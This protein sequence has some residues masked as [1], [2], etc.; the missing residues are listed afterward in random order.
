M[1]G[2]AAAG[3][4]DQVLAFVPTVPMRPNAT[5]TLVVSNV[6]DLAGNAAVGQ[7]YLAT[8]ATLDTIGPTIT[9]LFLLSGHPPYAGATVPVEADLA[10]LESNATV[11]FTQDFTPIGTA[12]NP[13]FQINVKMPQSGATTIRA[14]ATDQYGNSGQFVSL[15]LN[16]QSNLPPT[17]QFSLLTPASGPAPSGSFVLAT[18]TAIPEAGVAIAQLKGYVGGAASGTLV[19][20]N[21]SQLSVQGT[22]PATAVA[23][24][25]VEIYASATD[26]LGDSSGQRSLAIP[27]SD[28]T[29]PTLAILAPA[30]NAV[31]SVNQPLEL[32][33]QVSDNSTNVALSLTLSG[34]ITATQSVALALAPNTPATNSFIVPLT[35]APT[36]GQTVTRRGGRD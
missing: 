10:G 1:T 25:M 34:G 18:V 35:G 20:T 12:T 30:S 5:Y 22:I 31:V 36:G 16:V 27:V 6:F 19:T 21:G 33:L 29:P 2:N 32:L 7:P 28:G 24:Q 3:V 9:N 17:L 23:G 13:P 4:N 15:V 26:I 14:T 8:F 11:S